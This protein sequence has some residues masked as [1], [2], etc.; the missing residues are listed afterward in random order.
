MSWMVASSAAACPLSRFGCSVLEV[1]VVSFGQSQA[2]V[3][4]ATL[5]ITEFN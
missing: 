5:A 3:A 4:T 1:L 2:A